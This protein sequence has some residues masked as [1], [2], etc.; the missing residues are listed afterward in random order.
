MSNI[1]MY[2]RNEYVVPEYISLDAKFNNDSATTDSRTLF[3]VSSKWSHNCKRIF[4]VDGEEIG[5]K[6]LIFKLNL[7]RRHFEVKYGMIYC[8]NKIIGTE[9]IEWNNGYIEI[10]ERCFTHQKY[11]LKKGGLLHDISAFPCNR[12]I[13]GITFDKKDFNTH[14]INMFFKAP[15]KVCRKKLHKSFLDNGY[16]SRFDPC[17]H[18]AVNLRFHYNTLTVINDETCGKCTKILDRVC[19]CKDISVSCFNSGK[20]NITGLATLDQGVIVYNFLKRFFT[21]HKHEI[22]GE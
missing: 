1:L 20:M 21:L 7:P 16:Y 13:S 12:D 2:V 22:I 11:L 14:M 19:D 4:T 10:L 9:E 3:F 15:F 18:A 5:K 6:V 8:G 17:S